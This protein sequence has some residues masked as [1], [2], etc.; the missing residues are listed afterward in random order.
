[1][2]RWDVR[3]GWS[4]VGAATWRARGPVL[5]DASLELSGD[6]GSIMRGNPTWDIIDLV[7]FSERRDCAVV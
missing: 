1:M 5:F 6:D 4:V 7:W 3:G 2:D